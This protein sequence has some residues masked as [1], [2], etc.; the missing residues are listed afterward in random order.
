MAILVSEEGLCRF[1]AKLAHE[2]LK[3]RTIKSCLSGVRYLHISEGLGDPFV[4]QMPWLQY[5]VNGIKRIEAEKGTANQREWLPITPDIL[6]SI[7]AI[8]EPR[9]KDPEYCDA[10]GSLL[11]GDF[12]RTGEMTVGIRPE[13]TPLG[14]RCC[15]RQSDN[16]SNVENP[17]K[18][19]PFHQDIDLFIATTGTD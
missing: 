8:W 2:G 1:V 6:R 18:T 19:D 12:L 17:D 13:C 14:T 11:P 3:H 15:S 5:M 16:P 10:L 7:K 9:R 4:Q